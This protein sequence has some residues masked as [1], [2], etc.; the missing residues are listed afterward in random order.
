MIQEGKMKKFVKIISILTALVLC[1]A[2]VGCAATD[3]VDTDRIISG[4]E[5]E[6]LADGTPDELVAGQK[7]VSACRCVVV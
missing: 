6:N 5:L 1:L 3:R 4:D 2:A 7:G